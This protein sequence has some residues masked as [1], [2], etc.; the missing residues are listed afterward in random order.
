LF[1]TD[2]LDQ[3]G[4]ESCM[5]AAQY[6]ADDPPNNVVLGFASS[7]LSTTAMEIGW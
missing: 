3:V 7:L 5:R 4:I 2:R 6:G 1:D